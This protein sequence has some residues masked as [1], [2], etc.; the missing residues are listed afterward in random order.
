MGGALVVVVV[1]KLVAGAH[2][3]HAQVFIG[4]NHVTRTQAAHIQHDAFALQAR[5]VLVDDGL[6]QRLVLG[7]HFFSLGLDAVIEVAG[8]LAQAG[9]DLAGAEEV[10]F[11]PWDPVLF[12]HVPADVVHRAVAVQHI[13]F[14]L[15]RVLDFG[16]GAVAGPLRNDAQTHFFEQDA[17]GPGVTTDVVV[18]NDG[19]VVGGR[20]E[21]GLV[22]GVGLVK[23]PVA[24]R[25]V[26]QV[27][28][29]RLAHAPETFAAHGHD[30]FAV[31]FL[32]L[33][34]GHRFDVVADQ[35]DRALGLDRDALVEREQHLDL[36]DNFF[37]LFVTA[38]HDVFLLKVRGELHRHKGVDAGGANVVVAAVGPGILA[39]A[40]R[41]M[42]DVNHV[43][44]GAPHH[45][46]G[47]SVSAATNGH[48]ARQGLDV[49]LDAA[50]GLAALI[51][52]Q[53]LGAPLGHFFRIGLQHF[54]DQGLVGGL[55]LFNGGG[56]GVTPVDS[57]WSCGD[58]SGWVT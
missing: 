41:A 37:Q 32:A 57:G 34:L 20:L 25:V 19:H 39:A 56:H 21:L 5:L 12:F 36:V 58:S 50:I 26:G 6:H 2:N 15:G 22:T 28:A 40:D 38:K 35:A 16:N 29:E 10:V 8:D 45:A 53:V 44:D 4:T 47:T 9:F 27:V 42:A 51:G 14:G 33:F 31:V 30:G 24:D 11:H 55:A 52:T 3:F 49:G 7:D 48:H 17:A 1:G 13:E 54:I 46:F 43:L 18:T 23:H